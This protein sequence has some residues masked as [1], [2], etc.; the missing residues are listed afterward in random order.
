MRELLGVPFLF[1]RLR[2]QRVVLRYQA[3]TQ[4]LT[5]GRGRVKDDTIPIGLSLE[6]FW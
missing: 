3:E 2:R 4:T 6:D 1:E 5:S